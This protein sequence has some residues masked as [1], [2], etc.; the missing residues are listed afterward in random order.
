MEALTAGQRHY[1][2][3]KAVICAK[4]RAKRA[5]GRN[6]GADG[7]TPEQRYYKKNIERC[8]AR[9]RAFYWKQRKSSLSIAKLR[10]RWRE[11]PKKHPSRI[12][13]K[14]LRARYGI[15]LIEWQAL[16]EKQGRRCA[17]CGT[18]ERGKNDWATDH[19]H[20]TKK[21]RGI[22]CHSC[23]HNLGKLGDSLPEL[24]RHVRMYVRY[25]RQ[26]DANG[27]LIPWEPKK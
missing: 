2:K 6:I 10:K 3:N 21:V 25:L 19:D 17:C 12:R 9:G 13:D 16:W 26:S 15:T 20:N 8:R 14:N 7:L 4:A 24:I 5:A 18:T 11:W 23:N 1:L 27:K 22:V